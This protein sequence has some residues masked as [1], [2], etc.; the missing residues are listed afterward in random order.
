MKTK[1]RINAARAR[2]L[3]LKTLINLWEKQEKSTKTSNSSYI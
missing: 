1:D 3:E 2:I